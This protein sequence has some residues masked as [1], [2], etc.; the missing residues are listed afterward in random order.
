M[1]EGKDV[2]HRQPDVEPDIFS[3]S[4]GFEGFSMLR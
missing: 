4:Q 1:A 2:E 3:T